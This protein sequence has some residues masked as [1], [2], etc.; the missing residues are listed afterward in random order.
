MATRVDIEAWL[1]GQEPGEPLPQGLPVVRGIPVNGHRFLLP[2]N[3]EGVGPL[4]GQLWLD[5]DNIALIVELPW[6][7]SDFGDEIRLFEVL[8][9]LNKGYGFGRFALEDNGTILYI[10]DQPTGRPD[11]EYFDYFGIIFLLGLAQTVISRAAQRL[12]GLRGQGPF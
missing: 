8:M 6:R 12:Q 11:R 10:V 3:V 5:D 2:F 1:A 9:E 4:G 7:V